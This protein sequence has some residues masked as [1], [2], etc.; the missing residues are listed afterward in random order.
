MQISYFRFSL[1]IG[2]ILIIQSIVNNTTIL[3]FDCL[4]LLLVAILLEGIFE[5]RLIF[6]I[7]LLADLFGH[8]Y[9][10]THLLSITLVSFLTKGFVNFYRV[11][12]VLQKVIFNG[13]FSLIAYIIITLVGLVMHNSNFGWLNLLI[14]VIIINPVILFIL[15]SFIIKMP[16]DIIRAE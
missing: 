2:L 13:I 3:Y 8:W 6:M 10:G 7:C 14:E 11:S 4:P 9:L 12:N 16:P 5:I 15:S 1:L